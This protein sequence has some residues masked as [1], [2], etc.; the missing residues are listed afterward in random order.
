MVLPLALLP[1]VKHRACQPSVGLQLRRM[2]LQPR[3]EKNLPLLGMAGDLPLRPPLKRKGM[4]LP[5]LRLLPGSSWRP[6]PALQ[7]KQQDP[8]LHSRMKEQ[9][10]ALFPLPLVAEARLSHPKEAVAA[11]VAGSFRLQGSACRLR[12]QEAVAVAEAAHRTT[13]SEMDL[14]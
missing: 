6:S 2:A 4:D 13:S 12:G 8:P 10:L 3:A 1:R 11:A 5:L 9:P 7:L 14:L